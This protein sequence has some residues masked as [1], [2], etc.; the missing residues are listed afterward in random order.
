MVK[1]GKKKNN[2]LVFI[3][4][5]RKLNGFLERQTIFLT[6]EYNEIRC[7]FILFLSDVLVCFL[8]HSEHCCAKRFSEQHRNCE[9]RK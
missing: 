2:L 3:V 7:K 5:A 6:E 4:A 8:G 1:E 9:R